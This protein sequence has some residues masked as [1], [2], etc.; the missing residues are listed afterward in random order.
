MRTRAPRP[1]APDADSPDEPQARKT[2]STVVFVG[3]T[4]L[5]GL[6]VEALARSGLRRAVLVDA[7]YVDADDARSLFYSPADVGLSRSYVV[8]SRAREVARGAGLSDLGLDA[9][10]CWP[11]DLESA[12]DRGAFSKTLERGWLGPC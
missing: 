1:Y 3:L 11:S 4:G 8:A 7:D 5:A 12:A 9:I 10:V 2:G 6:T